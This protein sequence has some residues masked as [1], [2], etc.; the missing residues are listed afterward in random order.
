MCP[1]YFRWIYE[2]LRPW[3]ETGITR[4]MVEERAWVESNFRLVILNGRAYIERYRKGFETRDLFTQWGILQLLRRYPGKLPDLDLVFSVSDRPVIKSADY[5]TGP[6]ATVPPPLFRYCG[7]DDTL[8]IVFPDWSFWGWA[9]VNIK[10]WERMLEELKQGDKRWMDKEA[11]AHWKGTPLSRNRRDLL[12]CNI[13]DEE[14]W[15]ARLYTLVF[16]LFFLIYVCIRIYINIWSVYLTTISADLTLPN[17]IPAPN[18][19]GLGI[20]FGI[21]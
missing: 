14:D 18:G 11:H 5:S 16:R 15:G 9:E 20:V 7:T 6:N 3:K 21:R 1:D 17:L 8:S 4:E 12:K 10:P 13:S 19:R 2:D